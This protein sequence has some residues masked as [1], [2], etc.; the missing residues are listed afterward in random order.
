V[1]E[2]TVELAPEA[3]QDIASAYAWYLE[4]SVASA[5]TWRAKIFE[6]IEYVGRSPLRQKSDTE[7]NRFWHVSK[8]RHSIVYEVID[9]TITVLAVA[10]HRRDPD[11]WRNE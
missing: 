10:H 2:Y 9:L 6:A 3:E 1:T 8:T 11:Y 5:E 7:G 4:Y